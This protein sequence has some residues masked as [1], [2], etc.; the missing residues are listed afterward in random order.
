MGKTGRL[1]ELVRVSTAISQHHNPAWP[2]S[3]PV[4]LPERG[5][6]H[7]LDRWRHLGSAANDAELRTILLSSDTAA[8]EMNVSTYNL[9]RRLVMR[10]Q[11]KLVPLKRPSGSAN[12]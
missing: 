7:V 5:T 6:I 10:Y 1:R 4:G 8:E 9:V 2:F 11:D 3:G 12:E